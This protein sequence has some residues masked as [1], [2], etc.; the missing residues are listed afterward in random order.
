[1]ADKGGREDRVDM[2]DMAKEDRVEGQEDRDSMGS[3][4]NS[5][6]YCH[7]LAQC[8]QTVPAHFGNI[9]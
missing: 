3:S 2:G 9:H 4:S 7:S 5:L 1:M 6:T 8:N